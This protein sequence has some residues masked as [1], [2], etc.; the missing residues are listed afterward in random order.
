MIVLQY[1]LMILNRGK[2]GDPGSKSWF[3][4]KYAHKRI[5]SL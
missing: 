4:M 1:D 3:H 5:I 2:H